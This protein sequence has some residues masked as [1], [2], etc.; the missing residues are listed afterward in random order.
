MIC[1]PFKCIIVMLIILVSLPI[2]SKAEGE[3]LTYTG[4]TKCEKWGDEEPSLNCNVSDDDEDDICHLDVSTFSY[5]KQL[6]DGIPPM[7]SARWSQG[8]PY[9][10]FCPIYSGNERALTGCGATAIAQ[11]LNYYKMPNIGFGYAKYDK[12]D[13]DFSSLRI[14]WA[15][16]LDI[17][18]KNMGYVTEQEDAVAH[19]M[20]MVGAA[21]K[22]KYG[23]SSSPYNYPSMMW[24]LQ[25]HLHISPSSRYLNRK[26]Y[27]T[28]EWLEMLN[29]ELESGR[30]VLY[31]G[32][33]TYPDRDVVGHMFV[34]DG[35]DGNGNYHFNFG[36]PTHSEDK[37]TD[38]NLI[39]QG[40]GIYPGV[41]ST[42]YHY[43]QAMV[44]NL[45][46][47]DDLTDDDYDPSA[48]VINSA[49]V[50]DNDPRA[51][52]I[53]AEGKV[54]ASFQFRYVAFDGDNM[55]YAMGFYKGDQLVGVSN[56]V[57]GVDGR[58]YNGG[59]SYTVNCSFSL[60]TLQNGDYVM[61]FVSRDVGGTKWI[62]GWDNAPNKIPC[63]VN[64][65]V[66]TFY[67]PDYHQQEAKLYLVD[68]IVE[69]ADG[70]TGG[71]TFEFTIINLS[72]CNF[73]DSIRM[74][75]N[76]NGKTYY[77]YQVTSIYDGQQ[78]KYK[79]FLKDAIANL[80]G[81]YVVSASYKDRVNG[82]W[83]DLA[84]M[85]T[86]VGSPRRFVSKGISVY[87]INGILIHQYTD[88]FNEL[89]YSKLLMALP[90]GVYII[91]DNYGS[92]K[93]TKK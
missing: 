67:L 86:T 17:Y 16:I 82:R 69:V 80:E 63:T 39:N 85:T 90:A 19:L 81:N 50:L 72:S 44:T 88:D 4:K 70:K 79:Y 18:D 48:I 11:I 54:H 14:D 76:S 66:F 27:S 3:N 24:G 29:R 23:S 31:R 36:H 52:V 62:R 84:N 83:I 20:L 41:Y 5:T 1:H 43:R 28:A 7:I 75:V 21:M 38:L 57:Y 37:Y 47:V 59:W 77:S 87:T 56:D 42:C 60:P 92:R 26:Y 13:V 71:H 91:K 15:N 10:K 22:M 58:G 35:H 30:P 12:V 64:N 93:F 33:C 34:I 45:F 32:D 9:N 53:S 2:C 73:E 51:S 89:N 55:R 61:S 49:I 8:D 25:H 46:P 78:I 6:D 65:G 40:T 74:N 68:D